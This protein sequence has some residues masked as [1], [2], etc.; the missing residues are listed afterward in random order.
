M[1]PHE[2]I[3]KFIEDLKVPNEYMLG[4][5]SIYEKV[6]FCVHMGEGIPDLFN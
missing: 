3:W 1:V 4:V 6:I 2:H 5:T